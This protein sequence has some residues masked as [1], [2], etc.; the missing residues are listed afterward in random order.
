MFLSPKEICAYGNEYSNHTVVR[1]WFQIHF[2]LLELSMDKHQFT[3]VNFYINAFKAD[4]WGHVIRTCWLYSVRDCEIK[5]TEL[6]QQWRHRTLERSRS[7][8]EICGLG[9]LF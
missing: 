2:W 8:S 4:P 3:S 5:E 7:E 1:S 9:D 6:M